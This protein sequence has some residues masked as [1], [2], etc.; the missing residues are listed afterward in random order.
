MMC[1]A[2]TQ[3][4]GFKKN[5]NK[6]N[7]TLACHVSVWSESDRGRECFLENFYFSKLEFKQIF[8][9][10]INRNSPKLHKVKTY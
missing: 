5:K 9:R 1:K 6:I 3:R 4:P 8:Y 10:R 7:N 2:I